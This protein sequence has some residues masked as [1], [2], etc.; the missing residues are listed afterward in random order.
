MPPEVVAIN[1]V[2]PVDTEHGSPI[3]NEVMPI[4]RPL[5]LRNPKEVIAK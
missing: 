3:E 1:P 4:E 5:I 2:Q